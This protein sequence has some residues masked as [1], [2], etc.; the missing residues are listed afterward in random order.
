[1]MIM[2]YLYGAIGVSVVTMIVGG[3]LYYKDTQARL[4]AYAE[5]QAV[6]ELNLQRSENTI[7][8]IRQNIRNQIEQNKILNQELQKAEREKNSLTEKLS[9]HN[10]QYLA[11]RKP[12]LIE[13][14]INDATRKVFDDIERVTNSR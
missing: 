10:L 14:R 13:K 11:K 8:Q 5:N 9:K 2:K 7:T 1:M 4:R 12:G 3:Y 6:L